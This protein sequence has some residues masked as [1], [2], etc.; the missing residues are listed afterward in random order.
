MSAPDIRVFQCPHC[1]QAAP[2]P[3]Q[4]R[5]RQMNLF[6]SRLDEAQRRW[7]VALESN[8]MRQNS[9]FSLRVEVFSATVGANDATERRS[10]CLAPTVPQSPP[11][12]APSAPR[13]AIAPSAA[14]PVSAASMNARAR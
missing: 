3:D 6:L 2:H 9:G 7:Y 10:R 13:W 12:S 1:Q 11:P 5:H 14:T 4:E 8:R